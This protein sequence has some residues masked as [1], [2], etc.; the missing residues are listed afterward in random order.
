MYL[1]DKSSTKR[2]AS[3]YS[4]AVKAHNSLFDKYLQSHVRDVFSAKTET[5]IRQVY[6][7]TVS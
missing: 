3:E 4:K 1:Y 5:K 7:E 6:L 2:I